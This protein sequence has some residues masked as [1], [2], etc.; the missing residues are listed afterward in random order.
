MKI[1]SQKFD[2]NG[3]GLGF[4]NFLQSK[5]STFGDADEYLKSK[6]SIEFLGFRGT[7]L[8]LGLTLT[9]FFNQLRVCT[10]I[11]SF[12]SP[13]LILV[14]DLTCR[15]YTQVLNAYGSAILNLMKVCFS[16]L[17][18]A[19]D[20]GN[21]NDIFHA[22][23]SRTD[24]ARH[25]VE[26]IKALMLDKGRFAKSDFAARVCNFVSMLLCLPF[27]RKI[28]LDSTWFGFS[29]IYDE[30]MKKKHDKIHPVMIYDSILDNI[31]F[32]V[33]RIIC[34]LERGN[35]KSLYL[36][37]DELVNFEKEY[38]YLSYYFDRMDLLPGQGV[39]VDD[40]YRR[41]DTLYTEAER[42]CSC[43]KHDIHQVNVLKTQMN[44]IMWFKYRASDKLKVQSEREAPLA[45]VLHGTPG[46]GK[47][48]LIDKI[49][50]ICYQNAII[51]GRSSSKYDIKMK[52]FYNHSDEYMSE[53]RISH[54]I[55]I[56]DDVDQFQDKILEQDGGGA[57]KHTIDFINPVPYVTNQAELANKGM[58]PF[59]CKYVVMTTNSFDAG[60]SKV[61]KPH[62]G[63]RR[64]FLFLDVSVR[65][66]YRKEGQTQLAGD[67]ADNHEMH[68]FWPRRYESV[69]TDYNE[70]YWHKENKCWGT[71]KGSP[72][73]LTELAIF[74]REEVQTKHYS[75]SDMAKQSVENFVNAPICDQCKLN[76]CLCICK[77]PQTLL[78]RTYAES[79]KTF[80]AEGSRINVLETC[81]ND[82]KW[83]FTNYSY[84]SLIQFTCLLPIYL[85]LHVM[86][87]YE[88]NYLFNKLMDLLPYVTGV[89]YSS[90]YRYIPK[91]I[92]NKLVTSYWCHR[93]NLKIHY[94]NRHK[95]K[96]YARYGVVSLVAVIMLIK[97]AYAMYRTTTYYSESSVP[98]SDSA[99]SVDTEQVVAVVKK[100]PWKVNYDNVTRV[101][102]KQSTI[103]MDQL[104]N[105]VKYNTFFAIATN[106][107][108]DISFHCRGLG[109]YGN[110]VV[111]PAH[112]F[113]NNNFIDSDI[114][115]SIYRDSVDKR[116]GPNRLNIVINIK[117]CSYYDATYDLIYFVHPGLGC[118][119]DVRP[120][121]RND[122]KGT[123]P[124][125]MLLREENG[126]LSILPFEA[127]SPGLI[128]YW[129]DHDHS[130]LRKCPGY[131][132]YPEKYS[133]E[134]MCGAP[135]LVETLNGCFIAGFHIAGNSKV[136]GEK[137]PTTYVLPLRSL[138]MVTPFL[139]AHS[140]DGIDL[141]ES[142]V[143]KQDLTIQ[144]AI[145]VKDPLHDVAGTAIVY[146]SLPIHRTKPHSNVCRTIMCEDVLEHYSLLETTHFSPKEISP[147]QATV[148]NL[149]QM[150]QKPNI[151]FNKLCFLKDQMLNWYVDVMNENDLEIPIEPYDISIGINGLD[152]DYFLSRLDS[153][154]SGGFAHKGRKDKY[155]VTLES[156]PEHMVHNGMNEE[157]QKEYD[158]LRALYLDGKRGNVVWDFNFKDEPISA[159]KVQK[160]KC[161]IF[162]SGP[163]HFNIMIRQYFLW[164]VPLFS[165]RL[166]HK[167]GMAIGANCYSDDWNTIY[168]HITAHGK[169][170]MIAGD[171]KAFDKNMPPELL[172]ASFEIL[173]KI[174]EGAGWAD[175]HLVIMRGLATDVCYPL[176]N[177]FGT[178]IEFFGSNPS[179][180]PFTT[181]LNGMC[182]ILYIMLAVYDIAQQ[183]DLAIN[184]SRFLKHV[185]IITY[186]DD[187]CMSS[188]HDEI[189]HTS[190]SEALAKYGVEYTMADKKSESVAFIDISQVE[191][192]KR[193]FVPD[194][195]VVG[196]IAAPLNEESIIKM[197][198]VATKSR[199]ITFKQQC[200]EI[201]DS[202]NR[203]YYQY[204]RQ[205]FEQKHA[206]L[207]ELCEKHNLVPYLNNQRLLDYSD[208]YNLY[209]DKVFTAES[210][211]YY[212]LRDIE[213]EVKTVSTVTY[214]HLLH[215]FGPRLRNI[216][217]NYFPGLSLENFGVLCD[218]NDELHN[219]LEETWLLRMSG[220]FH[221]FKYVLKDI[222][223][224][225]VTESD[226]FEDY[227]FAMD[228]ECL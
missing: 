72:M 58:I 120:Y 17:T 165:G 108:T 101:S 197:L 114:K 87:S 122:F 41:S 73:T 169:D 84:L 228:L 181:P 149:N 1:Q 215:N 94:Q 187:N 96:M 127:L 152:S 201:I 213:S 153:S 100:N 110:T 212:T 156:T 109:L 27:C 67:D 129:L 216:N 52:Y 102:G 7:W 14:K 88:S 71:G 59:M 205:I 25:F 135:Y 33:D 166:R 138:E 86:F 16:S 210:S 221:S 185:S 90:Y 5:S 225:F 179:G 51:L 126:E 65:P 82:T 143:T 68:Y 89:E 171:Y 193:L 209:E 31:V 66:E 162:N 55:C 208:L 93:T 184:Y 40:Y 177:C 148:N 182:N 34:M 103:T 43:F 137:V 37:S 123:C 104:I 189:N 49:M 218:I 64:R 176:S 11:P 15:T 44:K 194:T 95:Y 91:P 32:F 186:G 226:F 157:I 50:T 119:R 178:L 131:I 220:H 161:R 46:I 107:K 77:E 83:D 113:V 192:L 48:A 163:L 75:Q 118:F 159:D 147:R 227:I 45:F 191:F 70:K 38:N 69:G 60:V 207:K 92:R 190:I 30:A 145:H 172:M 57:L 136:V 61:F 56:V 130:Q 42:L 18:K 116:L 224:L 23:G 12:V 22:E 121:L 151:D 167:F 125:K 164:C 202:A 105:V 142:Y 219:F 74:L 155:L 9:N 26:S 150:V 79:V 200:A 29:E 134:G 85:G 35:V 206:F 36:D 154:T 98:S 111:L 21:I 198:T 112:N 117:R 3:Q 211:N 106:I 199:S 47:S 62:G 124:G 175:E 214:S 168:E 133:N 203:E 222:E 81:L 20:V 115:I 158:N 160:Q 8:D 174:A 80:N 139:Q 223:N 99:A 54:E 4:T 76:K 63:A 140:F 6:I 53:F 78:M 170:R 13:I 188:R 128:S 204:G 173:I 2:L 24:T 195:N 132:A 39:S 217:I 196:H 10:D 19:F 146:G 97:K 28:G 144:P 183:K 180:H 141:N